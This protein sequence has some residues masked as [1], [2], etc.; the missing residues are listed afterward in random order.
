MLLDCLLPA[1]SRNAHASHLG[2]RW[3][4]ATL[5]PLGSMKTA[6]DHM[7][8][9]F[10]LEGV[11]GTGLSR[12]PEF[13]VSKFVIPRVSCR[14]KRFCFRGAP[15]AGASGNSRDEVKTRNPAGAGRACAIGR[16]D[17]RLPN[18][19]SLKAERFQEFITE[20]YTVSAWASA[21]WRA[22]LWFK[23]WVLI[24]YL[25]DISLSTRGE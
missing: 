3:I 1:K 12:L 23:G 4:I 2:P 15:W 8:A 17:M 7:A 9:H 16:S 6:T 24:A 21:D 5:N 19:I 10:E 14:S 11:P 22:G 25:E 18:R 13:S 20:T